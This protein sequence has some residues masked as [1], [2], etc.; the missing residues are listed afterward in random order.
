MRVLTAIRAFAF[1]AVWIPVA[2]PAAAQLTNPSPTG[3]PARSPQENRRPY[4]ALFGGD[5]NDTTG[6]NL[7]VQLSGG[8][9][10]NV[11]ATVDPGVDPRVQQSGFFSNAS[12]T[13]SFQQSGDHISFGLSGTT[14]LRYYRDVY[15]NLAVSYG[16]S[17][18]LSVHP[19]TKTTIT[20]RGGYFWTPLYGLWMSPAEAVPATGGLAPA[21]RADSPADYAVT[22]KGASMSYFGVEGGQALSRKATLQG[23]Y[24]IRYVD[25]ET[26]PRTERHE[27]MSAGLGYRVSQYSTVRASYGQQRYSVNPD[28]PPQTFATIGLG[29]DYARTLS[30]SGRRTSLTVRPAT[31]LTT[32]DGDIQVRLAGTVALNHEMGRTWTARVSYQ[33]GVRFLQG[34]DQGFFSDVV[35]FG[36]GGLVNR[37]VQMDAGGMYSSGENRVDGKQ[38]YE[39]YSGGVRVSYAMSRHVSVFTQYFYYAYQFDDSV[40]L[41]PG[42]PRTIDRQGVRFGLALWAPLLR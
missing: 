4:R 2:D 38:T 21:M 40:V 36:L 8:Y 28:L 33:R 14:D 7:D 26:E 24:A 3:A 10:D 5:P 35:Q 32:R 1:V 34:V 37:R 27:S 42:T 16:G 6:L 41:L 9:D 12:A 20:T 39:S 19:N 30:L 15:D 17:G 18:G 31:E 22:A 25:F 29:V 23:G 11:L 13:L